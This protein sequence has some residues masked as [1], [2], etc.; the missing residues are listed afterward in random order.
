MLKKN[1]YIE[2]NQI[3]QLYN[4]EPDVSSEEEN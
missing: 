2:Q 4:Y 1:K 3:M